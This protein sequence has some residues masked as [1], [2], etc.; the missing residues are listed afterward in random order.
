MGC[1]FGRR[2]DLQLCHGALAVLSARRARAY[3]NYL[4][5]GLGL[6]AIGRAWDINSGS[7][8][9]TR[10]GNN[11]LSPVDAVVVGLVLGYT[12]LG[13]RWTTRRFTEPKRRAVAQVGV[14]ITVMIA[15]LVL[16]NIPK[17]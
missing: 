5:G 10:W 16:V 1:N 8:E 3:I 12:F 6:L 7:V 11:T 2:S 14:G 17:F 15:A 4:I 9:L 13:I